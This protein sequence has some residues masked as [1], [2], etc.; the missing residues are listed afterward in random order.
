F[1]FF[2]IYREE[3]VAADPDYFESMREDLCQWHGEDPVDETEWVRSFKIANY[4]NNKAN[5]FVMDCSLAARLY[6]LTIS[7]ACDLLLDTKE[8]NDFADFYVI[9]NPILEDQTLIHLQINTVL[10][11]EVQVEMYDFTGR[12]IQSTNL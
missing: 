3:A 7:A 10:T 9:P 4:Q 6:C 11:G 5:P 8:L 12:L 2:S 1:Y